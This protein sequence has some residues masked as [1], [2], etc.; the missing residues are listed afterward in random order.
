MHEYNITL[1]LVFPRG[2]LQFCQ[3]KFYFTWV[4]ADVDALAYS[5]CLW[6]NASASNFSRMCSTSNQRFALRLVCCSRL[7]LLIIER[8][9]CIGGMRK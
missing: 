3:R 4:L 7:I 6:E 8:Y 1:T 9:K 2:G 5:S